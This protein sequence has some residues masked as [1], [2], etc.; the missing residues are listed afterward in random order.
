VKNKINKNKLARAIF[1]WA[2]PLIISSCSSTSP[3][4][5]DP[6]SEKVMINAV[7]GTATVES[8][9]KANRTIVLRHADGTSTSYECGPEVRNFNQIEVGDT[10]TATMAESVAI[11][12]VKGGTEP[13]VGNTS[14]VVKAPLGSKPSGKMVDTVGFTATVMGIDATDRMVTLQTMSGQ[15]ETV[16]AGPEVD[17]TK[18]NVGDTVGVQ[19]TRAFAIAVTAP[20][21]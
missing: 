13:A 15:N 1:I 16:K 18:I 7:Q 21:H 4:P 20:N 8:V 2:I 11:A 14:V 9:D 17:L 3:D 10:I 5:G 6:P 12:L 19:I